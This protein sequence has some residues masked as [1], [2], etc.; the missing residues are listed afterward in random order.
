MIAVYSNWKQGIFAAQCTYQSASLI[1][2]A[3]KYVAIGTLAALIIVA[4]PQLK[5]TMGAETF[6][7][8]IATLL[9]L[10]VG[11]LGI[12]LFYLTKKLRAQTSLLPRF[13]DNRK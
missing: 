6:W 1:M 3:L 10:S 5:A 11:G 2:N 7:I 4:M 13:T 12:D 9:A 8:T